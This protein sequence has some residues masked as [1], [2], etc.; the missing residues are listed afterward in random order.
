MNATKMIK[1]FDQRIPK[2]AIEVLG[3]ENIPKEKFTVLDIKGSKTAHR[4][5]EQVSEMSNELGEGLKSLVAQLKDIM[6]EKGLDASSL[7]RLPDIDLV[8][9]KFASRLEVEKVLKTAFRDAAKD[10]F[11]A[12]HEEIAQAVAPEETET[13]TTRGIPVD[14]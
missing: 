13:K 10:E 14:F 1:E 7:S 11:M 9:E 4:L 2:K 3:E 8:M 5:N 12:N 6:I